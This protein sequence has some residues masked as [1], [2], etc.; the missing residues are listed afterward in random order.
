MVVVGAVNRI[1]DELTCNHNPQVQ[2]NYDAVNR[3]F[4]IN[5]RF[6]SSLQERLISRGCLRAKLPVRD[7]GIMYNRVTIDDV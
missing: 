3:S 2:E 1:R 7:L 4:P 6:I 5:L